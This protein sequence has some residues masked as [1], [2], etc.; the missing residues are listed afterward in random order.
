MPRSARLVVPEVPHH[1]VQRGNRRQPIFFTDADRRSYVAALAEACALHGVRCLAW[2]LMDNHV[3][4]I[5]T[6]PGGDALRAVLARTHTRHAMR[7]NRLHEASGHLFQGRFASYPMDDAHLIAAARY[8]ENNPV[9]AGLVAAA[10]DWRWS[11]ARAHLTGQDDG[12]T[13]IAALGRHLGNWRA[14]LREGAE[15]GARPTDAADERAGDPDGKI[16]EALRSGRPLG[17]PLW[18]ATVAPPRRPRGRQPGSVKQGQ[19]LFDAM[20]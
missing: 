1:V 4:L 20:K 19:S 3:H 8:V 10:G 13:D 6:P 18:C 15:A 7:I 11:S 9:K 16:A 12:L 14:Y 2:C 5:L 17:S